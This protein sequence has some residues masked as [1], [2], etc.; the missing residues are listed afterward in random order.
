[1]K[2]N[3]YFHFLV[4]V[5]SFFS[6]FA[7]GGAAAATLSTPS[8]WYVPVC[9]ELHSLKTEPS[10]NFAILG[11]RFLLFLRFLKISFFQKN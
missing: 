8:F 4:C 11:K 10:K 6:P 1:M 2:W 9:F 7:G 3:L 5:P